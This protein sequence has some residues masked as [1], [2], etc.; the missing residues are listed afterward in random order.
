MIL[1]IARNYCRRGWCVIPIPTR[2]KVPPM[3]GWQQLR[4]AERELPEN[5]NGDPQNIGVHLGEPS[6]WLIDID[7]DHP[8]AVELAPQFLPA[9]PLRFG[10]ASKPDS[11][12]EYRVTSSAETKKHTLRNRKMIVELRSTGAQ[13]VFPGS[14]HEC[15]E[16]IEWIDAAAE[17][18]E[19]DPETLHKAVAKL[20]EEVRRRLGET[21]PP[22][23]PRLKRNT[24][25][26]T[27]DL[28]MAKRLDRWQKYA[29]KM[30]D[31]ISGSGGHSATLQAA[32]ECVRFGLDGAAMREAMEWWNATKCQPPWTEKE[33]A[34]KIDS[35]EEKAGHERGSRLQR[36]EHRDNSSPHSS[37]S[38]P[39]SRTATEIAR[40]NTDVGN[41]ARLEKQHG[42]NLRYCHQR[43]AWLGWGGKRWEWDESG[44]AVAVAK[45]TA[46]A[47]YDEAAQAAAD[48]A[49]A[50]AAGDEAA[51]SKHADRS[52]ALAAWA[53]ASQKRERITAMLALAQPDLAINP[54]QLDSDPILLNA[55]NGTIDLSTGELCPHQ[56]EDFITKICRAEFHPNA[57]AP[58][59]HNTLARIFRSHPALIDYIQTAIG[60]AS[61]GLTVEQVLF[62]LLGR[63]ANGKT[64]LI[65]A[66]MHSLGDYAAKADPDLLMMRDGSSAHPCNVADLMGRRLVICSET[67]EGRR[68]D[69]S[70]LKDLVG[71]TRLKA[72][73]MRENF[74]EYAATHKVFLYSNHK[75]LV[76]GNDFGFWRRMRLIPFVETIADD[77]KDAGLLA[78]LR[79]ETAGILAWIVAGAVRWRREGLQTPPE[80]IDATSEYRTE[81]DSIGAFIAEC[82]I[83]GGNLVS[84]AADLYAAYSKWS[85]DS[86][87][88]ALSQKRLGTTLAERG[89]IS[90]RCS[91]SGRKKW[92]GIGLKTTQNCPGTE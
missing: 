75:P 18:A 15:G 14:T 54:D 13:T 66:V 56:R 57:P 12:W 49:K 63:G 35:A 59:F 50:Q 45:Q 46:L 31:A 73:F 47:I 69:E 92:V 64:T 24:V 29:E 10:R 90:E 42:H 70:R 89:Y 60:Y 23:T 21:K 16:A 17:P 48:A 3:D 52:A 34:H 40:Q 88:H 83:E 58:I 86:G 39:T 72:R 30:P 11:H 5:F 67:N 28:P 26:D 80:V 6:G 37:F 82:C 44:R 71:E 62:F 65:D 68:F 1:D 43:G 87:E 4:L 61:T 85:D 91:Y 55:G 33:L 7:L 51:A 76:R 41:A 32:C 78:K 9:T 20:A 22:A 53:K 8:L 77:E 38:A 81:M 19:I 74:F 84:Y 27:F 36:S 79:T 25:R 2:S